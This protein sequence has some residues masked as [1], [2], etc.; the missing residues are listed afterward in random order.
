ML[1]VKKFPLRC[2]VLVQPA[3]EAGNARGEVREVPREALALV[4]GEGDA[5]PEL[6]GDRYGRAIDPREKVFDARVL[7]AA[8]PIDRVVVRDRGHVLRLI[9]PESP[10]HPVEDE[11][12]T[13]LA[14]SLL[15]R[16]REVVMQFRLCHPCRNASRTFQLPLRRVCRD[17]SVPSALTTSRSAIRWQ[18]SMAR[19]GHLLFALRS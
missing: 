3:F 9:A 14:E 18:G 12:P 6:H 1:A 7:H 2:L 17:H 8:I 10:G 11:K 15:V 19:A 4:G 13:V 16:L 5:V